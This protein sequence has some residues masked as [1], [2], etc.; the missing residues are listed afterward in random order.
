MARA[1][2]ADIIARLRLLISDRGGTPVFTDQE[3]QDTLDQHRTDIRYLELTPAQTFAPGGP[4]TWHDYYA[5]Y[6][7]QWWESDAQLVSSTFAVLTPTTS[8][9]SGG[10]WTFAANQLPPVY[11]VGKLFD[12][13][14]AAADV[15]E[16]WI[17]LIKLEYGTTQETNVYNRRER[18]TTLTDLAATYRAKQ[19]VQQVTMTRPDVTAATR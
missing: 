2:M 10:H 14:A 18:V 16:Q 17:A 8:D 15:L 3:L 13:Y 9:L 7:S 4:V 12:L 19:A 1:T 5:P 11:I 6:D